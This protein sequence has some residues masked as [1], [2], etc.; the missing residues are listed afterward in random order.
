MNM[1]WEKFTQYLFYSPEA[2]LA[3]DISRMNFSDNYWDQMELRIRDALTRMDELENGATANPDEDRMVGHYWLRAP[4]K[5]PSPAIRAA[6]EKS[7][8]D[9]LSFARAVHEGRITSLTKQKFSS[10]VLI[11]IGGSALGPQ[12]INDALFSQHDP[13]KIYFLDNT[14]PEGIGRVLSVI[15]EKLDET[16]IIVVSKSGGTVET[17]NGMLEVKAALERKGL[18]FA[19][20]ALAIT[21]E[22]SALD[23]TALKEGWLAR[24]PMWDWVGGRTSVTSPVGLLPALLQG[25]DAEELLRGAAVCDELTRRK[26]IKNNPAALLALMWYYATGGK[27]GTD[28]VILPYRDR[29]QLFP[30]YLQQLVMESLGKEKDLNGNIVNQGIAVFGNKGSTDQ[31]SYVQ[32]LID[33][34]DNAFV[35]FIEVLECSEDCNIF[36]EDGITSG[37]YLHAFLQGTRKALTEKGRKSITISLGKVSPFTVGVLIALYERTVGL[38]ANLVNINAYHQPAVEAGKR[39]AQFT[40]EMQRKI[41]GYMRQNPGMKFT[42][43]E[44]A[45]LL[46]KGEETELIFKVLEH[47]SFARIHGVRRETAEPVHKSRY[48]MADRLSKTNREE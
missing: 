2:G 16:L 17:R 48:Y 12:F 42:A 22:G 38:Y 24:F 4:Q 6:V 14:D 30:K 23:Q 43:E 29:L 47:L 28:M 26:D 19:G 18:K 21:Q 3:L 45:I 37:D 46:D 9:M 7:W 41:L 25:F 1:S 13:M 31:H 40:V 44:L 35:T 33:G 11:G 20:Q 8:L 10:L 36:V 5:A 32:Q 34:P 15:D 39:A 27:G